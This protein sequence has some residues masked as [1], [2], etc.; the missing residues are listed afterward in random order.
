MGHESD[1]EVAHAYGVVSF[2]SPPRASRIPKR[3]TWNARPR[4][5]RGNHQVVGVCPGRQP[6]QTFRSSI[7]KRRRE[8][9]ESFFSECRLEIDC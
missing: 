7:P 6:F 5:G 9:S 2:L 1:T 3:N 4:L 8:R